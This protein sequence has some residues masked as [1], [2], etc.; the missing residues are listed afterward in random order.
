MHN[1]VAHHLLTDAQPDSEQWPP[2]SFPSPFYAL[3][4]TQYGLEYPF[5]QLGSVVHPHSLCTPRLLTG[6]GGVRSR[7]VPD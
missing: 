2:A 7:K 3:S 5:G 1:A 4:T 6:E